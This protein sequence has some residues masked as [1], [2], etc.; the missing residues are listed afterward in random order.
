MLFGLACPTGLTMLQG[1]KAAEHR[2]LLH[3]TVPLAETFRPDSMQLQVAQ[4]REMLKSL[5]PDMMDVKVSWSTTWLMG[6]SVSR[7]TLWLSRLAL[8]LTSILKLAVPLATEC[9][10]RVRSL[11]RR[12]I[13]C[14]L[15]AFHLANQIN[16]VLHWHSES[17]YRRSAFYT[18][19]ILRVAI[20]L[21]RLFGLLCRCVHCYELC[22]VLCC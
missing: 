8:T 13:T 17:K 1:D 5:A 7:R 16:R 20:W 14:I 6:N 18:K 2:S 22:C 21:C 12:H 3:W 19:H 4:M 11:S 15:Q 9:V 10:R